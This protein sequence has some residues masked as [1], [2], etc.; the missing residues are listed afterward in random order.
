MPPQSSFRLPKHAMTAPRASRRLAD[1][2]VNYVL[3]ASIGGKGNRPT[4]TAS[5]V[6]HH[7]LDVRTE[8]RRFDPRI[9]RLNKSRIL[10]TPL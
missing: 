4:L 2:S 5:S 9:K 10:P 3:G 6:R 8:M 1:F 7:T